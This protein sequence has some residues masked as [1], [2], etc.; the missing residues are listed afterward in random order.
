M[1]APRARLFFAL[2][3]ALSGCE[4]CGHSAPESIASPTT[5]ASDPPANFRIGNAPIEYRPGE[6]PSGESRSG[7]T[8]D[9]L[10]PPLPQA[11]RGDCANGRADGD[12][13]DIDCGGDCPGCATGRHC[14]LGGDCAS[15]LCTAGLCE[16]PHL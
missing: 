15:G 3:L 9:V 12:E 6:S 1:I 8:G 11:A 4:R 16:P 10:D 7:A 13:T 14:L 2:A 5:K